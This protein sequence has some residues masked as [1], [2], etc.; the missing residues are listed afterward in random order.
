ME[1]SSRKLTQLLNYLPAALTR[2]AFYL[3]GT[4]SRLRDTDED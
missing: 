1:L 4:R 2:R 3:I